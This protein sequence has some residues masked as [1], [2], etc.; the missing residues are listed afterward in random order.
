MLRSLGAPVMD[1]PGNV[2]RRHATTDASGR[3]APRT[4]LTSWCTAGMLSSWISPGTRT[5]PTCT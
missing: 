4:V 2:A 5:L 1:P 3:R